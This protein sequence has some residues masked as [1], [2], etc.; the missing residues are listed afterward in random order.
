MSRAMALF[1]VLCWIQESGSPYVSQAGL[2]LLTSSDPPTSASQSAGIKDVSHG[3]WPEFSSNSKNADE[4]LAKIFDEIVLQVFSKVPYDPSF[5]ETRT[6]VRS[7]TKRDTQKSSS[8]QKSLNNAAFASG[9]NEREEHLAKIFDEILLQVF[10]KFPYDP[11]FNEATAVRSIT[12][13]DM[14]KGTSVAWNS[15]KP[16]YF[17]GSVDKIPDKD[18]LSEEKNFKESC[19][20]HRDLREQLTTVDKETLQGAAK[21]D[22]HF[23]TMPCGQL[24]H[25]L[26]KNTII[27]TVSGV[28]ILMAIVL[29]LLGLASYIRKKQP[30]SP[31]ANTTYNIFMMD[32]KT[33]WHNSEEKNFTK[34]A[35]KQKQL[36]SSSCV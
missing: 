24:L 5:D 25:F 16:E 22:A 29:L 31:L 12:K 34:H 2:E 36:K 26:Q 30:S 32:G 20:F 35:K 21:P 13:T 1:F 17:L 9:S 3:T 14:R 11:S 27:A 10:P 8:Q 15:P 23:R 19:L 18:H 33:W 4:G 7:I 6:A 28:A